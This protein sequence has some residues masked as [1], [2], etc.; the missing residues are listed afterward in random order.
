MSAGY[1]MYN[2]YDINAK[3][4]IESTINCDMSIH[5]EKYLKYL[6]NKGKILDVGFGSGRDMIYFKSLGYDVYGIDTSISF[7][8]NMLKQGFNVECISICD[9]NIK[10]EYD[11]IWA[12]ASLLH[13]N[14]E[15][16][17]KAIIKCINSLKENGVLYCSFKHGDKEIIKD[18]RYFNYINE[19]IIN[20]IAIKNNFKIIEIYKSLEVRVNRNNEEW[21]NII[22]QK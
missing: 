21:I 11:G 20:I 12:C 1:N 14:R 10:D 15:N 9:L 16:L 7:V 5:Y 19:E 4:Y 2:Y 18:D 13:I 3:E 17:E 6:P 8:N 22:I